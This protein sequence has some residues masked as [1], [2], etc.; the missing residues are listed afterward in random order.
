M[1]QHFFENE[2]MSLCTSPEQ[3]DMS[4]NALS[5]TDLDKVRRFGSFRPYVQSQPAQVQIKLLEDDKYFREDL[6]KHINSFH[7]YRSCFH[8][9]LRCISILTEDLPRN[10]LGKQVTLKGKYYYSYIYLLYYQYVCPLL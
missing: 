3:L 7:V 8:V 10:P 4:L 9:L 6:A 5:V 2:A 1:L